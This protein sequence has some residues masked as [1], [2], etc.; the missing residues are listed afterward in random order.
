MRVA[1]VGGTSYVEAELEEFLYALHSKYP[2]SVVVTGSG[3]GAE[4][5]TKTLLDAIGHTVE[6]P[7][8]HPEWYG[9][10]SGDCQVNDVLVGATVIVAVG[11]TTGGRVKIA[12]DIHKRLNTHR[13]PENK[14]KLVSVAAPVKEKAAPKRKASKKKELLAA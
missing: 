3:R 5:A 13:E 2:E 9:K 8:E 1:V 10:A 6:V 14:V 12:A 4:A 11:S 7:V